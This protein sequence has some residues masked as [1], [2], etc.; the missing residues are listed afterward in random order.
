MQAPQP[1]DID[2]IDDG[3]RP[4]PSHVGHA[5]ERS[6]SVQVVALPTTILKEE[7]ARRAIDMLRSEE[8]TAR[9]SA[10]HRLDS[11]AS[12]LGPER[13]RDVSTAI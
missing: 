4:I 2:P 3:P 1:M 10:A 9:I 7:D 11:I 13:T 12:V 5:S 6:S 8:S